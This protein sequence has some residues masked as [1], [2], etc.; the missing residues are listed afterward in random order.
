MFLFCRVGGVGAPVQSVAVLHTLRR[1]DVV[2]GEA[3]AGYCCL[4]F[5]YFRPPSI[6]FIIHYASAD[7]CVSRARSAARAFRRF[8]FCTLAVLLHHC[9]CRQTLSKEAF[10][11]T[12]YIYIIGM[13]MSRPRVPNPGRL[14]GPHTPST[15]RPL[16]TRRAT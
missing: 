12:R 7:G 2:G 1:G 8:D 9:S 5:Y 4:L 13:G 15:R 11:S 14:R 16:I 3:V 10:V 6:H